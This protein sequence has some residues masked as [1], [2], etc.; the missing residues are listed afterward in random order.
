[1]TLRTIPRAVVGGYVAVLRF[2]VDGV[3]WLTSERNVDSSLKLALDRSEAAFRAL[4]GAVLNDETLKDDARR[5]SQAAS[6]RGRALRLRREADRRSERADERV[7]ERQQEADRKRTQAASAAADKRQRAERQRQATEKQAG[8]TARRRR[9]AT[10]K[11][12]ARSTEAIEERVKPARLE[13][14]ETKS[15]ALEQREA[16]LEAA[17]ETR[18]LAAAAA[19]AKAE[20]KNDRGPAERNPR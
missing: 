5:R 17:D 14:L 20:R 12:A 10:E 19:K 6:E 9:E 11:S 1:M 2:P 8:Q 18:R 15:E 7:A 3:L 16:A 4:A 13:Q